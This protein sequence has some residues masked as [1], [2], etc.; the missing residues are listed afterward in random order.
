MSLK[1]LYSAATGMEAQETR[2]NN[3]ANNLSNLNTV[4][5]KASRETFEDMVY[6]QVQTPGQKTATNTV[7]PIG[8]QIGHGTRLV[9]VYKQFTAGELTQTNR[10]LDVAIEGNGFIKVTLD[11]GSSA[12]TRDGSFRVNSEG[13]LVNSR[14][15]KIDGDLTIP[16]EAESVTIGKDGTV[17]ASLT[18]EATATTIGNIQL[19]LFRNP[20][21]LK[22]M[23]QNLYA[24]TEASGTPTEAT[25][26]TAGAGSI[27]QGF[28]ENSNVNIAEELVSMII[29]QRSYEANSKVL[30]STSEMLRNSN[31]VI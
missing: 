17:S 10:E 23:G 9:G 28:V 3:I 20:A 24:E 27:A 18:G 5:Y 2:I 7:S 31:N 22:A 16:L 21:G 6:E 12:Y 4:G 8:I 15:Y 30:S 1:A 29:A 19:Q 11:D 14:G 13:I 25:P 26:G